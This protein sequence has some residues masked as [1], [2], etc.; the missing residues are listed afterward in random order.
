MAYATIEDVRDEGLPTEA[1]G[2]PNDTLVARWLLEAQAIVHDVTRNR[3][4][5]VS[6]TF[7]FDGTNTHLLHM[8]LPIISV[9]S[10]TVNGNEAALDTSLY[11]VYNGQDLPQDDRRNPKIELRTPRFLTITSALPLFSTRVF[12]RGYDQTVV[13]TWGYTESD[14]S[15]PIL[16]RR[17]TV[18]IVMTMSD[19]L[20]TKFAGGRGHGIGPV[21]REKTDGHELQFGTLIRDVGKYVLPTDIENLLLSFKAP[22][23]IQAPTVRFDDIGWHNAFADNDHNYAHHA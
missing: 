10:L 7:V 8:P 3:F 15:V 11:R 14:G 16:I 20:Y 5:P 17:A 18:A 6:G 1:N 19:Q 21:T 22:I 13:G 4:E 9:T 23:T 12:R 2:G